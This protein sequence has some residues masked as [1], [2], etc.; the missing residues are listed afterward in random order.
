MSSREPTPLSKE[1]F[2]AELGELA[3][4]RFQDKHPFMKLLHKGRLTK[5]H[6]RG[7][8]LNRFYF[9]KS[10]PLKDAA[11]IS[12]CPIPEI[13]KIWLGRLMG[14]EGYGD[15]EGDIEGWLRL[16]EA[17]GLRRELVLNAR[18]LPGVKYAVDAYL[19]FAR[20]ATWLQGVAASLTELFAEDELS[21]RIEAFQRH[22]GWIPPEGFRFFMN[23]LP[24]ARRDSETALNIV[25][26]HATTEDEQR[27][28]V[29]AFLFVTDVV[30]SM[31]DAI[32]VAYVVRKEPLASSI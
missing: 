7:W 5:T 30:W 27:K 1:E 21:K 22:Y 14:R 28:A 20:S 24:Q 19:H 13:R 10:I 17:A 8:I 9:Q 32:Y 3:D 4:R 6:L 23:R 29:K 18:C 16:A 11:I 12:N 25:L 2:L 15:Q 31:H 26:K